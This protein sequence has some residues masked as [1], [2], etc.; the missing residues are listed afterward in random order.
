M[1]GP[2][3]ETGSGVG[4]SL[5]AGRTGWHEGLEQVGGVYGSMRSSLSRGAQVSFRQVS[6]AGVLR[7]S[8]EV[9]DKLT[10]SRRY[11]FGKFRATTKLGQITSRDRIHLLPCSS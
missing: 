6:Q 4:A 10:G 2:G 11:V 1:V 7:T 3:G 9:P 8:T 5:W